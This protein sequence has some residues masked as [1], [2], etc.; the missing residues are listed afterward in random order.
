MVFADWAVD[1]DPDGTARRQKYVVV[2]KTTPDRAEAMTTD[3]TAALDP[4]DSRDPRTFVIVGAGQ[5]GRWL[6]LTLRSE[7]FTGRIVWFGDEAHAAYDRPPLSK[8][9]LQGEVTIR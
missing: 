7:G 8:A 2:E 9:V 1:G 5:A 3:P 4:R 6:V